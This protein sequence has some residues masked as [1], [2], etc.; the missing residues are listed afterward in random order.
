MAKATRIA[1]T[2]SGV[3]SEVAGDVGEGKRNYQDRYA[4]YEKLIK[5]LE[6]DYPEQIKELEKLREVRIAL[7]NPQQQ[8]Y[9]RANVL[10]A[11]DDFP[12]MARYNAAMAKANQADAPR[13]EEAAKL[14]QSK[15][16]AAIQKFLGASDDDWKKKD[17][18]GRSLENIIQER[19]D[20]GQI[21]QVLHAH[22][23]GTS[24]TK[25][26]VAEQLGKLTFAEEMAKV[27]KMSPEQKEAYFAKNREFIQKANFDKRTDLSLV[28]FSTSATEYMAKKMEFAPTAVEGQARAEFAQN[29][30]HLGALR[31][32]N[33][34]LAKLA[35]GAESS[36]KTLAG[37]DMFDA[38]VLDASGKQIMNDKGKP[39]TIT[40][41]R[42][43]L[44]EVI[45]KQTTELEKLSAQAKT[46]SDPELQA[47]VAIKQASL[48]TL[49]IQSENYER[50]N[51]TYKLKQY[52]KI[53]QQYRDA[54]AKMFE[55]VAQ[56]SDKVGTVNKP[57][58][59]L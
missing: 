22:I 40:D 25:T 13:Y 50:Q 28:G 46:D 16:V 1:A 42:H 3:I 45:K 33:A 7:N 5:P 53:K 39:V 12:E 11:K 6:R 47:K 41:I 29:Q 15:D 58:R 54:T 34:E 24:A 10:G 2:G 19:V 17:T 14:A 23:R 59:I 48:S 30:E 21:G 32:T 37:K 38:P 49:Q 35:S 36:Y 44:G 4:D 27:E 26:A 18:Q 52:D 9:V 43:S 31:K 8:G 56:I 55:S 57:I 51:L 20:S